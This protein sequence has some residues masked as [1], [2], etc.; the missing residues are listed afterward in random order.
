MKNHIIAAVA[1]VVSALPAKAIEYV[2]LSTHG[3]WEAQGFAAEEMG[4]LLNY[5]G[6]DRALGLLFKGG[7]RSISVLLRRDNWRLQPGNEQMVSFLFGKDGEAFKALGEVI[8]ED[9]M[10]VPLATISEMLSPMM[11]ADGMA[12]GFPSPGR[13]GGIEA[14]WHI[15][16][17]GLKETLPVFAGCIQMANESAWGKRK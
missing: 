4:C 13:L 11:K 10:K 15:D 17:T 7:Y 5:R 8:V 12:V 9:S 14:A 6:T 16:T 1:L 2:T 3:K